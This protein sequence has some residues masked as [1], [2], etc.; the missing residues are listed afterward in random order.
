MGCWAPR[1]W[2]EF[3]RGLRCSECTPSNETIHRRRQLRRQPPAHH[4][5]SPHQE[6]PLNTLPRTNPHRTIALSVS[7]LHSTNPPPH[8][9]PPYDLGPLRHTP[10]RVSPESP[11]SGGSSITE[12][13]S[14]HRG[15]GPP[16]SRRLDQCQ[17]SA[18]LLRSERKK[19]A[20]LRGNREEPAC[21]REQQERHHQEVMA[22][23]R[24]KLASRHQVV[25]Q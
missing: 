10:S 8:K 3:Q 17:C 12:H 16:P 13:A 25:P 11:L 6:A 23:R 19:M 20:T 2:R 1:H 18:E 5:P 15:R 4:R 21:L 14:P 24:E 7:S 22:Y 9:Y